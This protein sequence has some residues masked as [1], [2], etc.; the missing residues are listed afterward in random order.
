MAYL[1]IDV[2]NVSE[3]GGGHSEGGVAPGEVG[4]YRPER[5]AG[6]GAHGRSALPSL[7]V[8]AHARRPIAPP[9]KC[10]PLTLPYFNISLSTYFLY[11]CA[12]VFAMD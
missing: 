11:T 10:A 2:D 6:P 8:R 9:I 1:P 3:S 12:L 4:Q 7:C 5:V